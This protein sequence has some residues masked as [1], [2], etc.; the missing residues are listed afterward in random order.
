MTDE[1][2]DTNFKND[3]HTDIAVLGIGAIEQHGSHLPVGTDWMI[4]RELSR[5][6]ASA[7]NAAL[8]PAI[9]VSMSECHGPLGGTLWLKPA[10]LSAVVRDITCSLQRQKFHDLLIVNCHGGNF[11]LEPTIQ[12]LNQTY[13]DIRVV[14]ADENWPTLVDGKQIFECPDTDIHAGE[15]ETSL[16]LYL[17]PDLVKDERTDYVPA[18]GREFLDYVSMDQISPAG[19]WGNPGKGSAEKGALAFAAQ[20]D[21]IEGFARKEFRREG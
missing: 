3:V 16:M 6:V 5:R 12:E 4:A 1:W 7:L 17:F 2:S 15:I 14:L 21:R 8:L 10:T 11:I 20:V 19:I 18:C 9:P 13:P